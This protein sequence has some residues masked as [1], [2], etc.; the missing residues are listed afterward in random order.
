MIVILTMYMYI[1][2]CET[3]GNVGTVCMS[4]ITKEHV[5]GPNH[6]DIKVTGSD[7]HTDNVYVYTY[8]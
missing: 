2:I 1:Y 3:V 7:R 5:P 4:A 8:L 6:I